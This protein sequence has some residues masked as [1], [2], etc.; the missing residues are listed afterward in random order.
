MKLLQKI[1]A[2]VCLL[3]GVPIVLL[4]L[5]EFINP[6]ASVQ[7]KSDALA[8]LIFLGLPPTALGS[9]FIYSLYRQ[10]RQT[11]D[12][13]NRAIERMFLEFVQTNQGVISPVLFA[14]QT[15]LSLEEAK[16]YL[17][18][19]EMQLNGLY[20]ATEAGGVIYRFPL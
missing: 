5:V 6:E 3:V 2:G 7:D 20:E 14:T 4:V 8:A 13:H 12:Q 15:N 16:R 19:K 1:A 17:D 18:E 11:L 10:H 9:W